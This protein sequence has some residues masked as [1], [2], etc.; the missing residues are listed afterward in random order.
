MKMNKLVFPSSRG[1]DSVS[2]S[3]G[4]IQIGGDGCIYKY[5]TINSVLKC[6]EN[7][8]IMFR[9][10]SAWPDK[11]ESRFYNAD[12][13]AIISTDAQHIC[14]NKVYACCFTKQSQNEASWKVYRNDKPDNDAQ[15]YCVQIKL[16]RT[17]LREMLNKYA[18]VNQM[19]LFEGIVDYLSNYNIEHLHEK[20]LLL[21][22][23][24]KKPNE[25][26]HIYFDTFTDANYL[27]LL[28]LKRKAFEHE[29]EV[30]FFLVPDEIKAKGNDSIFPNIG[31]KDLI[32]EIRMDFNTPSYLYEMFV[33]KCK[34][35]GI[36]EK[37]IEQFDVY[38]MPDL[39]IKIEK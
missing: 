1:N 23:G 17:K 19:R 24:S 21:K 31:W 13:S 28:L 38:N 29:K 11:Y 5:M 36:D 9:E 22:D 10:P 14:N 12:F 15:R 8:N 27:K 18:K 39:S 34:V 3:V 2:Y 35:L 30:R 26:Y 37:K 4:N 6:F 20:E 25:L 32:E 16:K 7:R 33:N